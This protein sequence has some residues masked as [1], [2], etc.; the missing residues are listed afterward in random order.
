MRSAPWLGGAPTINFAKDALNSGSAHRSGHP[1]GS[2]ISGFLP[3]P[4]RG[5]AL[6]G[7][8]DYV[9]I[10]DIPNSARFDEVEPATTLLA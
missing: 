6:R 4:S 2:D 5:Q 7:N 8:N 3:P 9:V 10:Q 1:E